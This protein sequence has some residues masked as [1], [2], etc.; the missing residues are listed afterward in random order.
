MN[1]GRGRERASVQSQAWCALPMHER[2]RNAEPAAAAGD[3]APRVSAT[4][5]RSLSAWWCVSSRR[6][7]V[8]VV[9]PAVTVCRERRGAMPSTPGARPA[10]AASLPRCLAASLPRCAAPAL[11]HGRSCRC[12][13]VRQSAPAA[14]RL[15]R[16]CGGTGGG[17]G[18]PRESSDATAESGPSPSFGLPIRPCFHS[19]R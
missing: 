8:V 15:H 5:T 9:Q 19:L 17:D 12:S 4:G 13:G 16:Q 6:V 10:F 1:H 11:F 3:W 14:T 7:V 2:W 18:R